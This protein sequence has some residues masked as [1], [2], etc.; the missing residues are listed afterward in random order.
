MGIPLEASGCASVGPIL[1][2]LSYGRSSLS[3]G[4][5]IMRIGSR[6]Y[7]AQVMKK[8]LCW[9]NESPCK[10]GQ[11]EMVSSCFSSSIFTA[12]DI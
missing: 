12:T 8:W 3:G 5:N 9:D 4:I 1:P 2:H 7:L 10:L 6:R 11:D